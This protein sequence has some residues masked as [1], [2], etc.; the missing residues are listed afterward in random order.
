MYQARP[1]LTPGKADLIPV[2]IL[3]EIF[4]LTAQNRPWAQANL[5][6]VCQRWHAI[7]LSTPGIHYQLKIRRA[8]RKEVVQAFVQGRKSRLHV[9]VDLNDEKDGS[10]FNAEEFQACFMAAAQAASRWSSLN[11]F[12]PPPHGEYKNLQIL[13]PLERLQSFGVARSFG[14]FLEPILTAI[15]RGTSPDLTTITL[16][17]PVA[18]LYLVQPAYLQIT[19]SL[20]ILKV[21]LSK[22]MEIPVDVLP[23]LHRLETF[24]ARHLCLPFYPPDASL[25][26]IHTLHD[27][28]LKSVSVQWMDGHVFPA[29]IHCKIIFPRH[30]DT[31]QALQ[32][33]T[34]PSCSSFL[35]HSNDVHP[36][37]QFRLPSLVSLD[38]KSGQ[39][40][41]WRGNPQLAFLC[42]V[43]AGRSTSLTDL[44]LDVECSERLLVYM[45]SLIPTL[46]CL[47]LG[48]ARPN[49]LSVAFF[50]GF[51]IREPDTDGTSKMVVAPRQTISPLCPS[52][53]CLHLHYRRWLRGPDNKS[54]VLALGDIVASRKLE[55]ESLFS[56]E[57]EFDEPFMDLKWTVGKGV[58]KFPI[59]A[60]SSLIMGISTPHAMIT[61]STWYPASGFVPLPLMEIEYLYLQGIPPATSFELLFIH[62]HM[63]LVPYNHDRL[64]LP[65]SLPSALPLFYTLRVLVVEYAIPLF[66]TGRTF[67]KL[68][69]CRVVK[70]DTKIGYNPNQLTETQMPVC[71]R[72]DIDDPYLLT[73][74]NLPHIRQLA[75]D[76]SDP[77]CSMIWE[78]Q[79]TKIANLS[80]L[81]LL[82]MKRWELDE[83]LIPIL[84]SLPLLETLVI[85]AWLDVDSLSAFLP[86]DANR[87]S[88]LK[89]T[90]SEGKSLAL[91]CPRLQHLQVEITDLLARPG[92][93]PIL[94]DIVTLRAE[95]GC[96][97][98]SFTFSKCWIKPGYKLEL[99]GRDGKFTMEKVVLP[100]EVEEFRLDI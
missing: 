80:G 58:K 72:V 14:E 39:W 60:P 97:L 48:L 25:P 42:P 46:K 41:N 92:L 13:Q 43:V 5:M 2:E 50:H 95:F 30:A 66:L 100:E 44:R 57:L 79:I 40:N 17:D 59:F 53:D 75:L 61:I 28:Y 12:S 87:I 22:R 90:E 3:S 86:M 83:D 33:I 82:H 15:S 38:V 26:L 74:F 47:W 62:D 7:M 55:A 21:L 96:P 36:L 34:M 70:P 29:L 93:L 23:H 98:K 65:P 1:L 64:P 77:D 67:H 68:E 27:L 89:Q 54:L 85:S 16:A 35:Y 51:I 20:T 49:A 71:T 6:L 24:E 91:L 11:L 10:D 73:T 94:K 9:V 78:R 84:R 8:T 56:L 31:I 63:E 69:R 88:G 37:S 18:V 32:P 99:I 45:L 52:L 76:F 4:L 19:H 81:N